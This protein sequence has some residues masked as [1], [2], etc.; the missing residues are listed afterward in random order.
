MLS[1]IVTSNNLQNLSYGYDKFGNLAS[2]KDNLRNLEETF[3]Y[4]KMNRLTDIYL[5]T[6][7]SQ[8]VYDP[9]GRMTSKQADGQTVF[10]NASFAAAQGQPAQPHAMKSAE[11][12]EGVF[13]PECQTITYTGFDKVKAIAEGGNTLA[14]TYGYDRQRIFMEEHANGTDRAKRYVGGCEFQTVTEG[15]TT[16]KSYTFVDSPIGVVA[17]VE[18]QDENQ[19]IHY[20]L[21]DHLGS[22]TTITDSQGNVEQELS[23]DA[24]GNPRNSE[25]WYGPV[26]SSATAPM[27]DRGFTGHEHLY[28]FGLINMNGRMYDPQTSSFLSV[29]AYV[30]SPDNSQSFNRYAYCLNNPLKYTDPSG[31]QPIGGLNPGNPF[32]QYWGMNFAAKAYS[33]RDFGLLQ[34]PETNDMI[35]MEGEEI[36]GG[37]GGDDGK[38]KDGDKSKQAKDAMNYTNG[39]ATLVGGAANNA[40]LSSKICNGC[41]A[42]SIVGIIYNIYLN[43]SSYDKGEITFYSF[44]ARTNNSIGEYA[45]TKIPHGIGII[46]SVVIT[47]VDIS[48]GFDNNIYNEEWMKGV[49]NEIKDFVPPKHTGYEQSPIIYYRHGW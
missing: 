38:K 11:T 36:V 21:K 31:W 27:F 42:L 14:Y 47:A 19:A 25:T 30:Q 16:N 46:P 49:L 35:W 26:S 7:H 17:V 23:F 6:T 18:R 13:P 20:I 37:G 4:D 15:T 12:A 40:N 34:L 48:G 1:N 29:D 45:L 2:R 43:Y 24:W 22:W 28:A 33:P 44:C 9:R 5:G 41:S 10:A 3:H 32:H 8:I 39:V